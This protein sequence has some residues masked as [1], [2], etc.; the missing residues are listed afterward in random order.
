MHIAIIRRD[1]VVAEQ[2]QPWITDEFF[3]EPGCQRLHPLQLVLILFRSDLLAIRN[4]HADDTQITHRNGYYALLRVGETR[5]VAQHIDRCRARKNGHAVVCFLPVVHR[6][7][8]RRG[9]FRKRKTGILGLGFLQTQGIGPDQGQPV[10]NLRQSHLEAV[11]I[12]GRYFH[13]GTILA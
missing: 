2:G 8:A 1:V 5:N 3:A 7:I 4:V 12:P 9:K 13:E 10:E 11:Y 6:L